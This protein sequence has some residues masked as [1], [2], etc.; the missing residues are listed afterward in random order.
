MAEITLDDATRTIGAVMTVQEYAVVKPALE[1]PGGKEALQRMFAS[2]LEQQRQVQVE[3]DRAAIKAF[4]ETAPDGKRAEVMA[5]I[6][7][8]D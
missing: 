2:F 4:A 8:R 1:A 6:N 3:A 7:R 5:I